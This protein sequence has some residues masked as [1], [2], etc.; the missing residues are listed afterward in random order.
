MRA[1]TSVRASASTRLIPP[2]DGDLADAEAGQLP[3]SGAARILVGVD[4]DVDQVRLVGGNGHADR[5]ADVTGTID[6][7]ALDAG[8][9]RHGGEVRVVG[10]AGFGMVEI[11]GELAAIQVAALQ[12]AD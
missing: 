4:V 7:H 12:A 5:I 9:A 1:P 8:R 2:A 10:L 6:L 11:G 3:D